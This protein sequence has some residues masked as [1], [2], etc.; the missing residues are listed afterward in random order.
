M[1][2]I[3][4]LYHDREIGLGIYTVDIPSIRSRCTELS[5]SFAA[6]TRVALPMNRKALSNSLMVQAMN[7]TAMSDAFVLSANSNYITRNLLVLGMLVDL[8]S[9]KCGKACQVGDILDS[10]QGLL[11][12]Q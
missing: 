10:A 9:L 6:T 8:A 5:V 11:S 2:A 1:G 4:T 3:A 7:T 12:T